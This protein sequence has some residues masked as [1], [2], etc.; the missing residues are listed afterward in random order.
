MNPSKLSKVLIIA[1]LVTGCASKKKDVSPETSNNTTPPNL[2]KSIAYFQ[3]TVDGKDKLM[4]VSSDVSNTKFGIETENS[5]FAEDVGTIY[6]VYHNFTCEVYD[7]FANSSEG[8]TLGRNLKEV[9][10]SDKVSITY[11]E[12]KA[13]FPLGKRSL[14]GNRDFNGFAITYYGFL[15]NKDVYYYSKTNALSD[16]N[17]IDIKAVTPTTYLGSS[18]LEVKG[19]LSAILYD[20]ND[21]PKMT[22]KNVS[23]KYIFATDDVK[24]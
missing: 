13:Y 21:V 16:D 4:F 19:T 22:L 2:E 5:S 1:L 12:F 14:V 24:L 9:K 20:A 15:N 23:F 10:S 7:L 8:F 17:F 11:E 3:G 18:A 6:Q